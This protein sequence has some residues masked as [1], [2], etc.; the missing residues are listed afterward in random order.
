MRPGG[1]DKFTKQVGSRGDG[2]GKTDKRKKPNSAIVHQICRSSYV[3]LNV[4]NKKAVGRKGVT[5]DQ[6]SHT[7]KWETNNNHIGNITFVLSRSVPSCSRMY[8]TIHRMNYS[9]PSLI[10]LDSIC[11]DSNLSVDR[12]IHPLNNSGRDCPCGLFDTFIVA[13]LNWFRRSLRQW[14]ET[15][16]STFVKRLRALTLLNGKVLFSQRGYID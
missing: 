15:K 10:N 3:T 7:G 8:S 11:V 4:A 12:T 13:F 9:R 14:W 6:H 5:C 16:Q 2:R 1:S